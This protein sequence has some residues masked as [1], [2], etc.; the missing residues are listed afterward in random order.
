M[1]RR[2]GLF[3]WKQLIHSLGQ[4][5]RARPASLPASSHP[6]IHSSQSTPIIIL[7]THCNYMFWTL[8]EF[9]RV[10]SIAQPPCEP[11]YRIRCPLAQEGGAGG[12][13]QQR[14]RE[15]D[16]HRQQHPN[17]LRRGLFSW[18]HLCQSLGQTPRSRSAQSLPTAI[19]SSQSTLTPH[20]I[21]QPMV[22]LFSE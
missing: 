13:Q 20:T 9:E 3:S 17:D 4:T 21:S 22:F 8:L 1:F 7:K 14:L 19:H 18:K 2:R 12:H 5:P 11:S 15:L 16:Q 6:P 10:T